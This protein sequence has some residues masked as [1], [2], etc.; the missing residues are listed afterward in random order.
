MSDDTRRP[1][2]LIIM[3][4]QLTPF[5]LGCYGND[6]VL[7]PEIDRLSAEGVR[8]ASAYSSSPLCTPARYAFM[9]GLNVSEIGAYDNAAGLSS[10]VPTFAH[11][12]RDAGYQTTLAGKM[13]FV[14]ADQLHGFESRLTTVILHLHRIHNLHI[15]IGCIPGRLWLGSRLDIGS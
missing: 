12:L 3:A 11:Y 10:T 4:D 8:F 7:T 6:S 14:G 5:A 13:H 1:N 2:I 15:S 9:T